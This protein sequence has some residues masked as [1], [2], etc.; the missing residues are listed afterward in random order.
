MELT[1]ALQEQQSCT[2]EMHEER[3]WVIGV[4]NRRRIT[5]VREVSL[6]IRLIQGDLDTLFCI[7]KSDVRDS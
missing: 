7:E 1:F 2:K 6:L 3:S 4:Y 5:G